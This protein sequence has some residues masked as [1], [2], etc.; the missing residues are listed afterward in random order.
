MPGV[1]TVS[2]SWAGTTVSDD[3]SDFGYRSNWSCIYMFWRLTALT[4]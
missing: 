4:P 1:N 3:V 2:G